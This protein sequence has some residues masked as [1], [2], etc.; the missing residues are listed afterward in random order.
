MY[1]T[2]TDVY[3]V[4]VKMYTNRSEIANNAKKRT[5]VWFKNFKGIIC[6]FVQG[7]LYN[8]QTPNIIPYHI[9]RIHKISKY[10]AYVCFSLNFIHLAMCRRCCVCTSR[11]IIYFL[12]IYSYNIN[13]HSYI[14]IYS[15][16]MYIHAISHTN[17]YQ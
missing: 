3:L 4:K 13:I 12:H 16:K 17:V 9:M 1:S 15:D 11:D 6:N 10:N 2:C 5:H 14:V 7:H 8:R